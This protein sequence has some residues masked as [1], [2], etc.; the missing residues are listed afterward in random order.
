MKNSLHGI[1]TETSQNLLLDAGKVVINYG[2]TDERDLGATMGGNTFKV[3]TEYKE[4]TPDGAKGKVKGLRRIISVST[5]LV[6][7]MFEMTKENI[8]LA[9]PGS[10]SVEDNVTTPTADVITRSRNLEDLDYLKNI[11]YLGTISG[12]ADPV[13]ITV[14]NALSDGALEVSG[15]DKEEAST[16]LTLSGH[17][18]PAA[19]D[20]E[21][22]E[23]RYP[24]A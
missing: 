19:M 15:E 11:T 14:Y 17:F 12:K 6:V 24:K 20:L 5:Q 4:V 21:P 3:E 23:I 9:L 8:M 2:E 13:V 18:D 22:W 1:T 7:N 10:E 16:E